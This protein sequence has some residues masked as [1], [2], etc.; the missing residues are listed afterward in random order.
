MGEGSGRK[1]SLIR[2]GVSPS[3]Q[4]KGKEQG[5][6]A[7]RQVAPEFCFSN[8]IPRLRQRVRDGQMSS[9]APGPAAWAAWG[10]HWRWRAPGPAR[11]GSAAS[12]DPPRDSWAHS[13]LRTSA[14]GNARPGCLL[15]QR[16]EANASLGE[17]KEE[18]DEGPMKDSAG[19]CFQKPGRGHRPHTVPSPCFGYECAG[20]SSSGFIVI[21]AQK[22][23]S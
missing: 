10:A 19:G 14:P 4:A 21:C 5:G 7:S 18:A 9:L 15:N 13:S 12:R 22:I 23:N 8:E 3:S 2:G 11:A 17:F 20:H 6:R 1:L 16:E